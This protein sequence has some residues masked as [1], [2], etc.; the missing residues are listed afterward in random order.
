M[1]WIKINKSEVVLV[2]AIIL[3]SI[4]SFNLGKMKA[5]RD[6]REPLGVYDNNRGVSNAQF[7]VVASINSDKYHFPWCSG[8][9]RISEKNKIVFEN[10][11]AALTAG[12]ILAGNCSK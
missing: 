12:Y 6:I 9:G 4:I 5:L 7:Q 8:A 10:E 1:E 3:I 2:L 11:Q